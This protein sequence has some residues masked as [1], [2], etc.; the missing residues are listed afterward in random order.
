MVGTSAQPPQVETNENGTY[1]NAHLGNDGGKYNPLHNEIS[2]T[3]AA[4]T[5]NVQVQPEPYMPPIQTIGVA[6]NMDNQN[7]NMTNVGGEINFNYPNE[8]QMK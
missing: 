3:V 7:Q 4:G 5:T 8:S 6:S 2:V 1:A